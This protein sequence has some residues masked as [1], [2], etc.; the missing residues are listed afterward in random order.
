MWEWSVLVAVTTWCPCEGSCPALPD[1]PY[2]NCIA[3]ATL[4]LSRVSPHHTSRN[5]HQLLCCKQPLM[6]LSPDQRKIEMAMMAFVIEAANSSTSGPTCFRRRCEISLSQSLPAA[7]QRLAA[8]AMRLTL[9]HFPNGR[10][11]ERVAPD[12]A[13]FLP[14]KGER[15]RVLLLRAFCCMLHPE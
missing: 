4:R 13:R 7:G 12:H 1:S 11:A 9:M 14:G 5:V 15:P 3:F 6:Q 2:R 10:S 8:S